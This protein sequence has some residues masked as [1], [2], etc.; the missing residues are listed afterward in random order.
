M[1]KT[2]IPQ[3]LWLNMNCTF[4]E[5]FHFGTSDQ[6][7]VFQKKLPNKSEWVCINFRFIWDYILPELYGMDWFLTSVKAIL[8]DRWCFISLSSLRSL[9]TL[10]ILDLSSTRPR[11][12]KLQ[13]NDTAPDTRAR[14]W[15]SSR[16]KKNSRSGNRESNYAVRAWRC[17]FSTFNY[18]LLIS[19]T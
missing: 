15:T 3:L 8:Y 2:T 9:I 4:T 7:Q 13:L 12:D 14:C 1:A 18:E 19:A 17:C 6:T 11:C 10:A 16:R 5:V